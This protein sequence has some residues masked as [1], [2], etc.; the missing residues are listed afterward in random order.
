MVI[1]VIKEKKM[2]LKYDTETEMFVCNKCGHK[3][4]LKKFGSVKVDDK[5]CRLSF[6]DKC[7]KCGDNLCPVSM[8][9]VTT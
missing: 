2:T 3:A 8:K 1:M 4:L 7:P 5:S 6:P 9:M